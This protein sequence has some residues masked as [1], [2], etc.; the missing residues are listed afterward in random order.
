MRVSE[1]MSRCVT[2]C[3]EDTGL[4]EVYEL[5]QKC[6]HKLVVVVDSNAHR[7]PIGVASEHTICEQIIARGRNPRTL[8]AGSIMDAR[9][10]KVSDDQSL[11]SIDAT[12]LDELTAIVVV[13]SDRQISG[14]ISKSAMTSIMKT[15]NQAT[16]VRSSRRVSEIPAF[17]WIQ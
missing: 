8:S 15:S 12:D 1:I 14:L 9:I 16:P 7:V 17:G 3:T 13:N 6:E 11:E 5:I 2:V 10:R 4:E